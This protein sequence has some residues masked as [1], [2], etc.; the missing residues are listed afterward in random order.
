MEDEENSTLPTLD[1]FVNATESSRFANSYVREPGFDALYVRISLRR[2]P[3]RNE[4]IKVLDIAN[5]EATN[6]GQGNFTRLVE[7]LH[8][9]HN[10]Y[11]E[12]VLNPRFERR[13]IKLGFTQ[14]LNRI[15]PSFYLLKEDVLH[16]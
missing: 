10:I 13:L 1:E 15:P 14:E 2:F 5:I 16:L 3:E 12:S 11:V 8:S 4:L 9:L 7:R 6:P